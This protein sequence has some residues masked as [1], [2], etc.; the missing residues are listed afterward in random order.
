[1]REQ[2]A[3][4]KAGAHGELL[5]VLLR[6]LSVDAL[7]VEKD[8]RLAWPGLERMHLPCPFKDPAPLSLARH[9]LDGLVERVSIGLVLRDGDDWAIDGVVD[10][11]DVDHVEATRRD[12]V[13]EEE[14]ELL[15]EGGQRL[16]DHVRGIETID[17]DLR[18]EQLVDQRALA[19]HEG[20]LGRLV[21]PLVQLVVDGEDLQAA[22]DAPDHVWSSRY[23][24]Y[25]RLKLV[26]HDT[27]PF[28]CFG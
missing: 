23:S 1:V 28:S 5:E 6:H 11:I 9:V 10:G 27:Q 21:A 24:R 4:R 16:D 12:A 2:Q 3:F 18:A 25:F 22:L 17:L 8:S 26:G 13:G 19:Q 20:E 15:G 7:D 14:A